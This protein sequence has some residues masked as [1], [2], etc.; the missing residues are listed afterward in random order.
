M[1]DKDPEQEDYDDDEYKN[2]PQDYN[3]YGYPKN[4]KFDW[5]SWE[6]WL[7]DA[8]EDIIQEDDNSWIIKPLSNKENSLNSKWKSQY[9]MFLGNNQYDEAV[10]KKKYFIS[11]EIDREWKNHISSNAAHFLKQPVYYRGLQDILN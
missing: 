3:E 10:W 4:F 9:F 11:D 2:Y 7:K 6:E 5:A 8:I 1:Y